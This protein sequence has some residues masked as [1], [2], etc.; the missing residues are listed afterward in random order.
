M[1][2][3]IVVRDQLGTVQT[4]VFES[5][6]DKVRMAAEAIDA[7]R[8]WFMISTEA[9]DTYTDGERTMYAEQCRQGIIDVRSGRLVVRDTFLEVADFVFS[10][11]L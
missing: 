4:Y 1:S 10:L 7:L 2:H 5:I 3:T 9:H 8:D 6:H 11:E